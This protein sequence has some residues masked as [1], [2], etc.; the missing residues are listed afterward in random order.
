MRMGRGIQGKDWC[1]T[2]RVRPNIHDGPLPAGCNYYICQQERGEE[3]GY[4]HWQGYVQMDKRVRMHQ[5]QD[6][7]GDRTIHVE[8]RKGTAKQAADYCRKAS[9][10]VSGTFAEHGE[11]KASKTNHMDELKQS[12][13]A[14]AGVWEL[15][16]E[17]FGSWA[18]A[19][20]ACDRYIQA[21][22]A[23]R[24]GE[25][26]PPRVEL[27]WGASRTGKTRYCHDLIKS[28]G[29]LAYIKPSGPWWDGYSDQKIVLFD[30]YDGTVPLDTLLQLLDGYGNTV[31]LPIKGSHINCKAR[32]F[33]FTSNKSIDEWYP[34]CN[35]EQLVALKR[36]FNE[37]KHYDG[38]KS[39]DLLP[40]AI[41]DLTQD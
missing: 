2:S 28:K 18:R 16:Q 11:L 25:Y 7:L 3:G 14:G 8:R 17:H 27:H 26:S 41:V 4:E 37:I 5:V 10:A 39:E 12:M 29:E 32:I 13:D 19:E 24:V 1:F 31:L 21:R 15:M 34:K 22:D 38:V 30:D 6:M 23:R 36:R 40:V 35:P 20:K 33:L 9:T